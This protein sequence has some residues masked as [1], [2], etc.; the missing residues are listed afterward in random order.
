MGIAALVVSLALI[1]AGSIGHQVGGPRH[2]WCRC[3]A[4]G[5]VIDGTPS[6]RRKRY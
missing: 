2:Y 5:S 6:P 3:A 1:P 4:R